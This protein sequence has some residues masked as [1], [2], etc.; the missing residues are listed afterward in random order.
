MEG[1]SPA[2]NLAGCFCHGAA[3]KRPWVWAGRLPAPPL[4][5]CCFGTVCSHAS[6]Q[7]I[8]PASYPYWS[9][10]QVNFLVLVLPELGLRKIPVTS[11]RGE[12]SFAQQQKPSSSQNTANQKKQQSTGHLLGLEDVQQGLAAASL[13]LHGDA[14]SGSPPP[15]DKCIS[16]ANHGHTKGEGRTHIK[17]ATKHISEEL[18]K[19][20]AAPTRAFMAKA[21][22]LTKERKKKK[23]E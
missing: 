16:S 14:G 9:T 4:K 23:D 6:W 21:Y 12:G 22:S 10:T 17:Q 3:A 11:L 5:C 20:D 19:P 8:G 1:S 15:P 18:N 13:R 7:G 2:H